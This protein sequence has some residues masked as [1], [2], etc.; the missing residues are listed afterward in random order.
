MTIL[1]FGYT[2]LQIFILFL[3]QK[4]QVQRYQYQFRLA[5]FNCTNPD[6][7]RDQPIINDKIL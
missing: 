6:S 4:N 2:Y 5:Y 7:Y 3:K 1:H